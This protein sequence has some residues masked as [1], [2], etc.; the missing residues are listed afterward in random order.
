[1]RFFLALRRRS[2]ERTEERGSPKRASTPQPTHELQRLSERT[3]SSP[4]ALSS[5]GWR[6]GRGCG[7]AALCPSVVHPWLIPLA[8]AC[9]FAL[10]AV[11]WIRCVD[12]SG[13]QT[14]GLEPWAGYISGCAEPFYGTMAGP[15]WYHTATSV[16]R[17]RNLPFSALRLL[18]QLTRKPPSCRPCSLFRQPLAE[19]LDALQAFLN[20]RHIGARAS[21]DSHY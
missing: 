16:P 2:G 15:W 18:I 3:A 11:F 8:R 4:P 6:R 1:M 12:V 10:M 5:I 14:G 17:V 21:A 19:A 7:S 9:V 13:G 20:V